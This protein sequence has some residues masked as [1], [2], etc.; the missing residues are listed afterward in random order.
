MTA[1][2]D[3]LGAQLRALRHRAGLTGHELAR[4][5][6]RSQ[7]WVSRI[8][9]N[10]IS[11]DAADVERI[12]KALDATPEETATLVELA[13]ELIPVLSA[14]DRRATVQRIQTLLDLVAEEARK[15]Q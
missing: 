15:L 4:R 11:L 1:E 2:P 3:S 6:D 10:R 8:E 12:T 9:G 14:S 7:S 13:R 5:I